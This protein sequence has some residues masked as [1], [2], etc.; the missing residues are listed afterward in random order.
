MTDSARNT[1]K[2]V[3]VRIAAS[4]TGKC[5]V[6]TARTALYNLLFARQ[7]GG[8]FILRIDDTD[9]Q[10]STTESEQ[11]VLEGLRWLGLE[12]DEGPDKGGPWG[13]YRQ[14]ERLQLYQRHAAELVEKDRA[15]YCFC[16]PE[17]LER[18]R[19]EALANGRMP[20]YSG[21]CRALSRADAEARRQA[22]ERPVV[23]L[24]IEPLTMSF[25]DLV[26]GRIELDAS[27]M[28]DPV[29]LKSDGVPTYSYATVVDEHEMRISHVLRGADHTTNT[30]VQLQIYEALGFEPPEFGHFA[31]LLNPDRSKISKRTGAVFIGEFRDEGYLPE[32]IVNHLA[33]CGWNPGTDQEVF[34]F[35][36]LQAAF[37]L[38]QCSSSNAIFDR[39]KL[40]WLNGHYIRQLGVE[41]LTRRTLPFLAGAGLVPSEPPAGPELERL[42]AI[43]GLE[44]ER[45]KT[46]YE[47]PELV[48][49]FF[50]DPD[51]AACLELLKTDR[52]AR[53][54]TPDEL[55]RAL[56]ECAAALRELEDS[57]WTA[58]P[59]KETLEGEAAKLGWKPPELF[60]PVRLTVSARQATPPLFETLE[61][62]GRSA[63]LRRLLAVAGAP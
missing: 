5:H 47:A 21:R 61:C 39:S 6:G 23:R 35:D 55:K 34:S 1:S 3:R 36:G 50:R 9:V 41:E 11:G 15:Y 62:V 16:S 38:D 58:L 52:F 57:S 19:K 8:K 53:K 22:G 28:G 37:A 43:I 7:R 24:K 14:S 30:F 27:L 10:R 17:E 63:T 12:W 25:T 13:P 20:R 29:I 48:T 2:P 54:H 32:A 49:F 51:P 44:Q 33:L 31:L 4:P 45:L 18:E 60:M 26:K 46:L 59:L 56:A 42:K 40:L